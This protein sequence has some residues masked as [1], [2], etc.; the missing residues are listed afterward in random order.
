MLAADLREVLFCCSVWVLVRLTY[1]K[2]EKSRQR[3]REN[4]DDDD[5]HDQD[6]GNMARMWAPKTGLEHCRGYWEGT[7][8]SLR[9]EL[10]KVF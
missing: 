8:A 9:E 6:H 4:D 2:I 7:A 10:E 1:R 3:L 5:D